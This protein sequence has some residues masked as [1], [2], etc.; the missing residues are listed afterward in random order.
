MSVDVRVSAVFQTRF[1]SDMQITCLPISIPS[2]TPRISIPILSLSSNPLRIFN[3]TSPQ[4]PNHGFFKRLH[5]SQTGFST[6]VLAARRREEVFEVDD[7][8]YMRKCVELAKRAIGC[9]SPNP[10][11][12]CVI[13]KDGDIV[14]QGF[15]PKAGQPHAEVTKVQLFFVGLPKMSKL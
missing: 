12:G 9:T 13:V 6:P 10:M 11:V 4:N 14:G 2:I 3:L 5:K 7:A 1:N 8:F 15:H